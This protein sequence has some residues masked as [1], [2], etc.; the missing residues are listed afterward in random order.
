MLRPSLLSTLSCLLALAPS[1]LALEPFQPPICRFRFDDLAH[2]AASAA[3]GSTGCARPRAGDAPDAPRDLYGEGGVLKVRLNFMTSTDADARLLYCFVTP[4]GVES[5]TLHVR[6]GDELDITLANLTPVRPTRE[7]RMV[8]GVGTS[9]CGAA[10]ADSSAVNLHFHGTTVAP[11]CHGD[12]VIHTSVNAGDV[13]AYHLRIPKNQPPGL[14]WY[15]PHIHGLADLQT[16]GGASGAIVV[17]GIETLQPVV[18]RLPQRLLVIRDQTVAGKPKPGGAVPT[19]DLSLNYVP[20]SYPALTPAA[21][22]LRPGR[23][24]FWRVLNAAADTPA[25]IHVTYDGVDQ[26]LQV[27]ALDGV[28]VGSE[29]GAH[30]GKP[31]A[32]THISVPAAGRAEFVVTTPPRRVKRATLWTDAIET[33]PDGDSDPARTLATLIPDPA[34]PLAGTALAAAKPFPDTGAAGRLSLDGVAITGRRRL[35]LSEG[36]SDDQAAGDPARFFI[37]VAGDPPHP[38]NPFAPPAI[39]VRQGAVEEWTIENRS[40]ELHEFHIHQLHFKLIKRDGIPL[41]KDEQQYLDTVN[42]PYWRGGPYPS[43]TVLVDFRGDV[44]GDLLYHCHILQHEDRGM[45]AMVRILPRTA[46]TQNAAVASGL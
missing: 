26:P 12:D 22:R 35:F 11:T 42:V 2:A 27:V 24:E 29:N 1:A 28:A 25:D 19:W 37:T 21:I 40:R 5:P 8:M 13:F 31:V 14:Y 9:V 41:P 3:A 33:G 7:A 36:G 18:A 15:H 32:M 16:L 30:P 46:A 34:A 39:V 45:M 10:F 6:P 17:D 43:V 44:T 38:F 23:R 20:I 4:E